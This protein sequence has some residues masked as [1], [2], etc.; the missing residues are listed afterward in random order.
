M[1]SNKDNFNILIVTI[2]FQKVNNPQ[3]FLHTI[4]HL[5]PIKYTR[6]SLNKLTA[7]RT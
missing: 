1:V 2:H 6:F 4:G 3:T 7:L 5:H